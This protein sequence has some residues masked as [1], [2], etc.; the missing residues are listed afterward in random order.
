MKEPEK[1]PPKTHQG[2]RTKYSFF[3]LFLLSGREIFEIVGC[4]VANIL[5]KSVILKP[6]YGLVAIL[7][8]NLLHP[9][10]YCITEKAS[11]MSQHGDDHPLFL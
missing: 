7:P 11:G 8:Y 1:V 9:L 5:I 2:N 6:L 3:Q 4:K 10:M